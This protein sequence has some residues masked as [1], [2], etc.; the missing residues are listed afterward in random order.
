MDTLK[1]QIVVQWQQASQQIKENDRLRFSVW[2][3][4]FIIVGYPILLI[5][6]HNESVSA[7]VVR[8]LER[9][10]RILRTAN[11]KEWFER[12]E[13]AAKVADQ[14][15]QYFWRA[16]S[17]GI[18]KATLFQTLNDWA[19]DKQLQNVQIRLEE[20][21]PVDDLSGIFRIS[22][23]VDVAFDAIN[24]MDFLRQIESSDT[25]IVVER[26]E[27]TQRVRPVHKL[28]IAAYFK[29]EDQN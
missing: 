12:S 15:D 14:I 22:G 19:A 10:A 29:I 25:K 13:A 16:N 3:I 6:D 5:S 26:M 7:D 23:Q 20:P 28:V 2:M 8:E 9:E 11:E 4:A 21:F 24:S 17:V 18:A 1:Q 27:I